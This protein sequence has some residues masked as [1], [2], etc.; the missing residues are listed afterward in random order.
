MEK[1][2]GDGKNTTWTFDAATAIPNVRVFNRTVEIAE[3]KT[4]VVTLREVSKN[5][6]EVDVEIVR[7]RLLSTVRVTFTEAP[8]RESA[9]VVI[10]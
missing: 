1:V 5:G 8:A 9:L 6:A 2:L 3:D 4:A 10:A 7:D